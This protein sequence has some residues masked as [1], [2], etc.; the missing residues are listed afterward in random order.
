MAA[1]AGADCWPAQ[2]FVLLGLAASSWLIAGVSWLGFILPRVVRVPAAGTF[3][4]L[5]EEAKRQ[6]ERR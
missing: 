1:R 3:E 5:H 4:R 6:M 2:Y